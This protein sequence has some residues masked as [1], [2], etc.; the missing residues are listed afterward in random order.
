MNPELRS[1]IAEMVLFLERMTYA[2]HEYP[3]SAPCPHTP[4]QDTGT[5]PRATTLWGVY[6]IPEQ[7]STFTRNGASLLLIILFARW[8]PQLALG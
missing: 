7:V 3:P 5:I 8:I 4:A 6:H 2:V 1:T